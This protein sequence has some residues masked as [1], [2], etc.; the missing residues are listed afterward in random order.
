M[1]K[2]IKAL[3][4]LAV[5]IMAMSSTFLIYGYANVDTELN[6][7]SLEESRQFTIIARRGWA[8]IAKVNNEA[9]VNGLKTKLEITIRVVE[10]NERLVKFEVLKG[11]IIIDDRIYEIKEGQG[12]ALLGKFGWIVFK[13]V[14][15]A[16][17]SKIDYGFHLE[18]M[19][20][21]EGP[22]LVVVG[23]SGILRN[24]ETTYHLRYIALVKPENSKL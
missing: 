10:V 23:L 7:A 5:T 13:G 2:E 21:V 12:R 15:E 18:G 1:K 16:S 11:K 8:K 4:I 20:H 3:I 14:G 19:L 24:E 22:R 17:T 6:T 9:D